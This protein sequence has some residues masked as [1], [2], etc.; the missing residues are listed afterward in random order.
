MHRI[1]SV[2]CNSGRPPSGS[3]S[4]EETAAS[5]ANDSS[6]NALLKHQKSIPEVNVHHNHQYRSI[7][8]PILNKPYLSSSPSPP[9]F[10]LNGDAA[11]KKPSSQLT[12][13]YYIPAAS[14]APKFNGA[15]LVNGGSVLSNNGGLE[16]QKPPLPHHDVSVSFQGGGEKLPS[17]TLPC[18]SARITFWE[19]LL[20]SKKCLISFIICLVLLIVLLLTAIVAHNRGLR[21]GVPEVCDTVVCWEEVKRIEGSIDRNVSACDDFY[22]FVCGK[23]MQNTAIPDHKPQETRFDQLQ[24]K[25]KQEIK[26]T[27]NNTKFYINIIINETL[28]RYN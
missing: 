27:V 21:T 12:D 11:A 7:P 28:C 8:S 23:W 9:I 16:K 5:G 18:D 24:D 14:F 6:S 22:N 20:F 19:M 13:K 26:G 3:V 4:T 25:V 15:L 2:E 17:K 1:S 10:M